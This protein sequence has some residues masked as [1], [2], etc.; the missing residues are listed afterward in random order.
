[1]PQVGSDNASLVSRRGLIKASAGVALAATV[2]PHL[3]YA[4]GSDEIRIGLVGC[5]GRGSGAAAQAAQSSP[6]TK[7][8][9]LADL[10]PDQIKNARERFVVEIEKDK[11]DVKDDMCFS[12]WDGYQ[13]LLQTN[14]N[15]VILA[16]PPGFRPMMV[17]AALEA[18]KNTFGEKPCAVDPVGARMVMEAGKIATDKNISF[19]AGTQRRHDPR[20]IETV[21]RIQDGAI[22]KVLAG[23]IYWIQEGLWNKPRLPEWSDMEWQVRDWL[24]FTW[25]SGDLIVEQ[26]LHQIDVANWVM[27][28]HPKQAIGLGGRQARIAP[29]YGNVYD[30]FAVDFEYPDG[31]HI[32]SMSRQIEGCYN[33]IS[34]QFVGANG[35]ATAGLIKSPAGNWKAEAS[36]I[37][38]Y[39]QEHADNIASIRAGKPLNEAQQ[40]AESTL[41]AIMGRMATYTGQVVRWK[42]MME[43][44][45][46]LM[47][48]KLEFGPLPVAPVAMPGKDKIV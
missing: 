4:A 44:K 37:N 9:A 38:P 19:V 43:S 13:K 30:H 3:A 18:G 7:L 2:A 34:E 29:S 45:L 8:V 12:G 31:T 47:P 33:R 23:Q 10:F 35:I 20:Y 25:L 11:Y 6:G 22:G 46:S 48:E 24:Y 1:M 21:K 15:Y 27:G 32:S 14:V 41:T 16:T 40:V 17:K 5:G 36:D 26:H 42:D 28:T 39:V